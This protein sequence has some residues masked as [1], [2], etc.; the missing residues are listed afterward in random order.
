MTGTLVTVREPFQGF[1]ISM[2]RSMSSRQRRGRAS[3]VT[4]K[5]VRWSAEAQI[6]P[7]TPAPMMRMRGDSEGVGFEAGDSVGIET[8][9][10]ASVRP[11]RGAWVM[12]GKWS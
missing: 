8:L 9:V 2:P 5:P 3:T 10:N 12:K 7:F 6:E 1:S 4:L 11:E